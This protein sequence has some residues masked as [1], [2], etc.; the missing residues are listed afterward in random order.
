MDHIF[1]DPTRRQLDAIRQEYAGVGPNNKKDIDAVFKQIDFAPEARPLDSEYIT[2]N[3]EQLFMLCKKL[4]INHLIYTGFAINW[5]LLLSPGGMADMTKY[6]ML[7]S[8][9][10]QATTAVENKQTARN[11][12]NKEEAL[13]R[14]G[15]AFGF[16]F[17]LDDF[18]TSLS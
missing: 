11:E 14:I 9:I 1:K 3:S 12:Q 16:V 13:W 17:D 5:C 4:G 18:L 6:G 8:T 7:C 10:R 2:E 15:L